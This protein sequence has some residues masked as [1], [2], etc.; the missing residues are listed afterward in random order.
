M[1]LNVRVSLLTAQI[2]EYWGTCHTKLSKKKEHKQAVFVPSVQGDVVSLTGEQ[3]K[4]PVRK[5]KARRSMDK[6]ITK[7]AR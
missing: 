1:S 4:K 5:Q 7:F 6:A 3:S 2:L